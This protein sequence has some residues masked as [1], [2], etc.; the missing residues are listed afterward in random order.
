MVTIMIDNIFL[1]NA[2][3]GS[4]KTTYIK[5]MVISHTAS[6]PHDN[7][8]CITFTNRAANEL[9]NQIESKTVNVSTIHSF[10][11]DFIKPYFKHPKIL[12]LYFQT[13]AEAIEDRINNTS[14]KEHIDES[15]SKYI[16]KYGSLNLDIIK[17]NIKELYYNELSFNSLYTGGL[18]HDALISFASIILG[19]FPKIGKRLSQKY[20]VIYID[21]YQDT[22]SDT[23]FMIFNSTKNTSTKVFFL[24]DKMQQIYDTYDGKFDNHFKEMDKSISLTVNYRSNELI[25]NIL[26]RL[27]NDP[28]YIQTSNP[29][30]SDSYIHLPRVVITSTIDAFVNDEL[31]RIPDA[32]LLYLPNQ[33][34]FDSIGS[35]NLF[36]KVSNIDDYKFGGKTN[37]SDVLTTNSLD[38]PDSLFKLIFLFLDIFDFYSE[39]NLGG[40]LQI[41]KG[42]EKIFS[43]VHSL[44]KHHQDKILLKRMLDVVFSI[45]SNPDK[46]INDL[47][48][49][50]KSSNLVSDEYLDSL[51][52][53]EKYN[54]V[55]EVKLEELVSLRKFLEKNN[56]STQHGVKGESH[57]S[58]FF[59]AE[60]S[61]TL[62]V[63]MYLFLKVLS[64]MSVSLNMLEKFHYK[65]SNYIHEFEL[66]KN[67]KINDLKREN[68]DQFKPHLIDLESQITREF[69]SNQLFNILYDTSYSKY[70]GTPNVT[71]AKACFKISQSLGVLN[72]YRLFYVGCS[73]A[74]ENLTIILDEQQVSSYKNELKD[75]LIE[76]GFEVV[77]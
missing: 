16:E 30:R 65:Y 19:K 59:I 2:P 61:N 58:V 20:Q 47:I 42:N 48:D 32:L 10:L 77:S 7:I 9:R 70:R 40:V 60:D 62:K 1:V 6:N 18:S 52:I 72:A 44:V 27:Y 4:G 53:E 23:L 67:I 28:T 56:V 63:K 66:Q 50:I 39:N 54:E 46:T 38:N 31:E 37:P 69:A 22:S 36:R 8:L 74:R 35:G 41:L 26:N 51:F 24:G 17:L 29:S 3:A 25:I 21:E 71:N 76:L 15:N 49:S 12:D 33:K 13:Y 73:R 5:R 55:F 45:Y 11:H 34:K 68:Y 43:N 57:N 14:N 64:N 75:K